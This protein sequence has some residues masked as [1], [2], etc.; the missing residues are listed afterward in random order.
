MPPTA[1]PSTGPE[2]VARGVLVTGTDTGVG[3]TWVT[4]ALARALRDAAAGWDA[5]GSSASGADA[6]GAGAPRVGV[7][8]PCETG[9]D[10]EWPA[11]QLPEGSDA[12]ALADAAGC[13]ASVTDILPC[14][15]RLPAAPSVAAAWQDAVVDLTVIEAAYARLAEQHEVVLVEG[16]GGLLVPLV[17]GFDFSD[18]AARLGLA[19]LVVARTGLGTLNHT[20]LTVRAARARGLD[21]IG[22]V[23]DA[24]QG[25][26]SASDRHNLSALPGLL[27]EVPVLAELAYGVAPTAGSMAAVVGAVLRSTTRGE[28]A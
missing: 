26:V 22:V 9:L 1:R 23:L 7:M 17:A 6:P 18:L 19:V 5:T 13:S 27:G 25:E 11:E 14:A 3:K 20:A 8:K 4:C 2:V 24:A 28:R 21:V 16:A 12:A 10:V 15:Y